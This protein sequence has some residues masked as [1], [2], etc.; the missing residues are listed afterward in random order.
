MDLVYS[1]LIVFKSLFIYG[2]RYS[3]KTKSR[4]TLLNFISGTAK[5]AIWLSRKNKINGLQKEDAAV[6]FQ[7]HVIAR[8]RVEFEFFK[9]TRNVEV[10]VNK[11]DID[12]VLCSVDEASLVFPF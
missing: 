6:I 7:R 4:V 2:P 3:T 10:F 8:V 9:L 1:F 5:I 12:N 11:W